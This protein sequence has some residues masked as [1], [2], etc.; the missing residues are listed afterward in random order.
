[1]SVVSKLFSPIKIGSMAIKNRIAMAPMAT[2]FA[3]PDGTLSQR[4]IDYY[5]ARAKGGAG[6]I[7]L[8]IATIDEFSP[9]VPNTIGLWD[10]KFIPGIKTLTDA[11]HIHGELKDAVMTYLAKNYPE[12]T[13]DIAEKR[14]HLAKTHDF[15]EALKTFP[16]HLRFERAML[17]ALQQYPDN[18]QNALLA[19][20]KNLLLMFINAYQS[21][22]FNKILSK[23]LQNHLPLNQALPGDLILSNTNTAKKINTLPQQHLISIK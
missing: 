11:I 15:T 14:Q 8:E 12:E 2:D 1:M 6:L 4:I 3:N 13:P 17:S 9:Y 21:Y 18:F 10:D 23:R 5:E 22:L 20:P 16:V 7:T 19:L